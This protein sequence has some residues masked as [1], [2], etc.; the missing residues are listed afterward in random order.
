MFRGLSG[1]T[2]RYFA[3]VS[4]F[5]AKNKRFGAKKYGGADVMVWMRDTDDNVTSAI[6]LRLHEE[7]ELLWMSGA[8]TPSTGIVYSTGLDATIGVKNKAKGK[9]LDVSKMTAI[10]SETEKAD[11]QHA[12][13]RSSSDIKEEQS[14]LLLSF[15]HTKYRLEFV[16]VIEDFKVAASFSDNSVRRINS[17]ASD[18]SPPMR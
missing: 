5:R 7:A 11:I 13:T 1:W 10:A 3:I 12:H 8:L 15:E 16:K 4:K 2:L 14:D 6:T 18:L 17:L 9:L